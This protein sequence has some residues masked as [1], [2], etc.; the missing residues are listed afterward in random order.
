MTRWV[1]STAVLAALPLLAACHST[2]VVWSKPGADQDAFQRDL[3]TCSEQARATSP[4]TFD[5]RT[6]TTTMDVQDVQRQQVSCMIGR[7]WR[8]TPQP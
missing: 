2:P 7:G 4:N 5:S 1:W 8:L 3:R 6:M